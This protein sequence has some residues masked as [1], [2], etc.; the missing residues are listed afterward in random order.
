MNIAVFCSGNGTNFQALVDASKKGLFDAR[1]TLMVCDSPHAY[2]LQR[3]EKEGIKT[4]LLDIDDFS[5]KRDFEARI[6]EELE[7]ENIELVCLAGYMR[8]LLDSFIEKY[9]NRIINIH[10]ALLPS[11]KGTHAIEDAVDY[12]VKVTGVTAHFVN[13]EMDSGPVIL[14]EP[15]KIEKSDT[16]ETLEQKIHSVEHRLY[17][18]AVRLFVEG[19]LKVAGRKV[20]IA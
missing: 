15:V 9:K 13:E 16:K 19:R 14:Q 1:I 7:K 5:C 18:E 2:A 6:I 17:P 12:G 20:E 4:L 11:F 10:P 8:L 3:A